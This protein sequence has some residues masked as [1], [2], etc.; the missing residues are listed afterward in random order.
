MAIPVKKY[1]KIVAKQVSFFK[2]WIK[3][4]NESQ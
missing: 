4:G 2:I 3:F 1:E